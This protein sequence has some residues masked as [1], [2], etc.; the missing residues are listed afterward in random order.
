MHALDKSREEHTQ[1]LSVNAVIPELCC[2][3]IDEPVIRWR[4]KAERA[5]AGALAAEAK[6][7]ILANAFF[8]SKHT[9]VI[10]EASSPAAAPP[11]PERID[12]LAVRIERMQVDPG[13]LAAPSSAPTTPGDQRRSSRGLW[14]SPVTPLQG[15]DEAAAGDGAAKC[16]AGTATA[17]AA[18]E[19]DAKR[20]RSSA[21]EAQQPVPMQCS[22][23]GPSC[24]DSQRASQHTA[25]PRNSGANE[26]NADVSTVPA[27]LRKYLCYFLHRLLDFRAPELEALAS[28]AG[29]PMRLIPPKLRPDINAFWTCHL[30]SDEAGRRL[31]QR[32][33]L[34]KG[35]FEVYAEGDTMDQLAEAVQALPAAILAP[36]RHASWKV[37]GCCASLQCSAH[38]HAA[39]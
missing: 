17:S 36:F 33:M 2:S 7:N 13:Q 22:P 18:V 30:P 32:S 21:G 15:C 8:A 9:R 34:L 12:T 1:Q 31:A 26:Q 14:P 11:T 39:W 19:S 28:L 16:A 24:N 4:S 5:D 23:A 20:L 38:I 35:F 37:P 25:E 29:V 10:M 3:Q 27:D 6:A